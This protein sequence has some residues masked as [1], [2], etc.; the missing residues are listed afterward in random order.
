MRLV[1]GNAAADDEK[2]SLAGEGCHLAIMP[3]IS[4]RC[5]AAVS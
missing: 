5:Q 3:A 4:P 2:D 1:G